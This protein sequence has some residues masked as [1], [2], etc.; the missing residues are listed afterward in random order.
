MTTVAVPVQLVNH[1]PARVI[2]VII[3]A[4]QIHEVIKSKLLLRPGADFG[5]PFGV[6]DLHRD[7]AAKFGRLRDQVCEL[8]LKSPG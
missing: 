8:F 7:F 5:D 3:D 4:A 6:S 1:H 2:A